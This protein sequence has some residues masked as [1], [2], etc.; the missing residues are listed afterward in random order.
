MD[1]WTHVR[2]RNCL[3]LGID[4]GRSYALT[5]VIRRFGGALRRQDLQAQ[6]LARSTRLLNV[7][8]RSL[9]SR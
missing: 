5:R 9:T 6:A 1:S 4:P 8:I 7:A 2:M 3:A